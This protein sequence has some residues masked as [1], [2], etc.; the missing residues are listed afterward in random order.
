MSVGITSAE[1][2]WDCRRDADSWECAARRSLNWVLFSRGM[3]WAHCLPL[4]Q[5]MT[6]ISLI[7][8]VVSV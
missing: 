7:V 8:G 4:G 5:V 1:G 3:R 6:R 2:Y